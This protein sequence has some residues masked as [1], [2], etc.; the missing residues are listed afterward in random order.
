MDMRLS[1]AAVALASLALG[2]SAAHAVSQHPVLTPERPVEVSTG[3]ARFDLMAVDA[4]KRRLLAAHSQ[5]GTLT[6]VDLAANKLLRE[7]PVGRSA[8]VAVD[9]V[10][11]RYFVSTAKGVAVVDR[12]SLRNTGF[13]ATPGPAD[14]M[15]FDP[16]NDRLYV[17]HDDGTELWVIDPRRE[18][19]LGRVSI[20]GAPEIMSLDRHLHRLL[21]NIKPK[22]ELVEIDPRSRKIVAHW[23]TLPTES[24]HGLALDQGTQ[25]AFVAG[26][27]QTV[28]I[29]QLPSGKAAGKIDIGTGRVDQIAIDASAQRLYCPSSG[30]L[31]AVDIRSGA[32]RVLGSA[33]IPK[34]T[35]SVAVDPHT[36]RVWIAYT[37]QNR[38]YVQAFVPSFSKD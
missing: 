2:A 17:G 34:G 36:H 24:P 28:S 16:Q 3:G 29:F 13:V 27:S 5:A 18:K 33:Q 21:V 9:E 37:D 19:L 22:N 14:A 32:E 7:V 20:P 6:I 12:N 25:R 38:S 4:A 26:H 1:L 30:R 11:N 8:D 23:S 15:L 35:H 31:V 10:D